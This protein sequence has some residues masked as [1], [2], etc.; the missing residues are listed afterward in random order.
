MAFLSNFQPSRTRIAPVM[1]EVEATLGTDPTPVAGTDDLLTF[2]SAVPWSLD[3]NRFELRPHGNSFTRGLD[4][5]AQRFGRVRFRSLLQ[6]SGTR[7]TETI[8]GYKGLSACLQACGMT[9]TATPATSIVLAPSTVAA[10]KTSTLWVNHAGFIHKLNGCVGNVVMSGNPRGA[11]E[12]DFDFMGSYVAPVAV[13]TTFDAFTGGTNRALP[14]LALVSP[15]INNGSAYT[16]FVFKS[17][18]FDAGVQMEVMD[19]AN[20]SNGFEMILNIDRAPTLNITIAQDNYASATIT[21]DEWF[22][23][24]FASTTHNVSFTQ[25]T[26]SGKIIAFSFPTAQVVNVTP[27]ANGGHREVSIDYKLQHA[28]AESEWSITI[29]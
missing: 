21:Y 11:I 29:T 19:N 2:D 16:G 23:D 1:A 4:V 14:F 27:Q 12:C 28:T 26:A 22:T 24:L 17:F 20:D 6:G 10:L 3:V 5:I 15:T 9:E 8:N 18:R 25:G 13:S 7:G